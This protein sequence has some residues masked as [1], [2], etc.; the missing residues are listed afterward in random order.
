MI[1]VQN[2][3]RDGKSIGRAPSIAGFYGAY[4]G[5]NDKFSFSYNVRFG[6]GNRTEAIWENLHRELSE[7][8]TPFQNL[9]LEV[10]TSGQDFSEAVD[11]LKTVKINA[12]GYVT[13]MN[14]AESSA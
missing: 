11:T 10:L 2:F 13:L 8:H 3:V 7:D 14:A 12:P 9:L 1:Y 4:T 5:I 6:H